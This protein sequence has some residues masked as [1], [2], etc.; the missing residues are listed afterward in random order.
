M[1]WNGF[2]RDVK[3]KWENNEKDCEEEWIKRRRVQEIDL[4]GVFS[5]ISA[6]AVL[7]KKERKEKSKNVIRDKSWWTNGLN[8][9][10]SPEFKKRV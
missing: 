8:N 5:A 9:W 4:T 10:S 2:L 3:R 7:E 1:D 6:A